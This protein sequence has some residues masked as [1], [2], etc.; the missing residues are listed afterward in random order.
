MITEYGLRQHVTSPTHASAR[1]TLDLMLSHDGEISQQLVSTVAV[2]S[3][4][5]PDHH[6]LTCRLGVPLPQPVT[7]SIMPT[8]RY[9]ELTRQPSVSTFCSPDCTVNWSWTL[10]ATLTCSTPM[11]SE[12]WTSTRRCGQVVVAVAS[13]TDATRRKQRDKPSNSVGALKV[14][15]TEPILGEYFLKM[16]I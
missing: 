13:T 12:C 6:L 7:T 15:T 9:V 16:E 4:C 8:V 2:E 11:S 3:V 10:M 1:N 14:G 5:F